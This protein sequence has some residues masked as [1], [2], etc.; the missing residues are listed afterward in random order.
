MVTLDLFDIRGRRVA[1]PF[2]GMLPA[3]PAEVRLDFG[4]R[5]LARGVYFARV[6]ADG[7]AVSSTRVVLR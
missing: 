3:G 7:T 6:A 2:A 4:A 5:S 1:T